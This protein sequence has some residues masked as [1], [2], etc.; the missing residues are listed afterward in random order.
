MNN[1]IKS[2]LLFFSLILMICTKV[3]AKTIKDAEN[4]EIRFYVDK[5]VDTCSMYNFYKLFDNEEFEEWLNSVNP[6]IDELDLNS[7][8]LYLKAKATV[9]IFDRISWKYRNGNTPESDNKIRELKNKFHDLLE[10]RMSA[11]DVYIGADFYE[12]TFVILQ[13]YYQGIIDDLME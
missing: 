6:Q 8:G 12:P 1:T 2:V 5:I 13:L 10:Q 7:Q 11:A 3:H 9:Y 4:T